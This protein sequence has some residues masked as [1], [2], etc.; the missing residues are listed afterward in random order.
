[1]PIEE[2]ADFT[3]SSEDIDTALQAFATAWA[4]YVT[5]F[6]A[7]DVRTRAEAEAEGVIVN[8]R[9]RE[10]NAERDYI[11]H[12]LRPERIAEQVGRRLLSLGLGPVVQNGLIKHS[13]PAVNT[14]QKSDGWV[15]ELATRVAAVP[16][17]H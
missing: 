5:A 1:M 2:A 7:A 10:S 12:H 3:G 6:N 16:D 11:L 17:L 8:G 15:A 9:L 14:I 13:N 4:A